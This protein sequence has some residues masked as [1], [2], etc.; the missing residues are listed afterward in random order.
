LENAVARAALS[1]LIFEMSPASS[2]AT[3]LSQQ[4]NAIVI[5]SIVVTPGSFSIEVIQLV[6]NVC[7]LYQEEEKSSLVVLK[8][9]S[10][11]LAPA[12]KGKTEI[13]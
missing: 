6:S 8:D 5:S 9:N 12:S 2:V 1:A 4:A 10:R 13:N 11:L 3:R 7:N